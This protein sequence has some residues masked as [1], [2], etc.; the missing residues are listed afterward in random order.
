M[1]TL[2]AADHQMSV[3]S[4]NLGSKEEKAR[5]VAQGCDGRAAGMVED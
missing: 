1:T 4:G 5:R 3:R 2:L